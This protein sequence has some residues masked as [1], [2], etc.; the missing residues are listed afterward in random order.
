MP[1]ENIQLDGI[2]VP[3]VEYIGTL[4]SRLD[5]QQA[6]IDRLTEMLILAQKARFGSS[7]EK[8]KYVLS[9]DFEQDTLFNEAEAYANEDEPEPII[10][11]S[12]TRKP[13]RTKEELA[14]DLPVQEVIIDLPE[15]KR[16]CDIC[17][18][19]LQPIG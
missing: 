2:P 16:I 5:K 8:G 15:D 13:K 10:V 3:V 17:E 19:E 6:Q 18:G 4:E 11:D 9:N 7:S 1:M 12:H 14:K